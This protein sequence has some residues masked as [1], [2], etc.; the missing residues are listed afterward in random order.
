MKSIQGW[1]QEIVKQSRLKM[2]DTRKKGETFYCKLC[3]GEMSFVSWMLWDLRYQNGLIKELEDW[4]K[5]HDETL[6]KTRA[7]NR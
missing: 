6:E 5:L 7:A 2:Q 3:E 4:Y 1:I